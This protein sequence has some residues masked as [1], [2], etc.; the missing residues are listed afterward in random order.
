[1]CEQRFII[2]EEYGARYIVDTEYGVEYAFSPRDS[3]SEI[4]ELLNELD[5]M[6][7]RH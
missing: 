3:L 2:K 5:D 4:V 1:M 7:I 6:R